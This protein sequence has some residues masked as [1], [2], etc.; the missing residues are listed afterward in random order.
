MNK[1]PNAFSAYFMESIQHMLQEHAVVL[2]VVFFCPV[3]LD[4]FY[5]YFYFGAI[6]SFLEHVGY[7]VDD[8]EIP[9][10]RGKVKL[11]HILTVLSP[12]G[13]ILGGQTT[14]MHDWHHEQ[15]YGNY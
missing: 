14:S 11:G 1:T 5:F 12:L 2:P 4:V 3:P 6:G 8:L 7:E 9:L 10:T 13:L 15:F